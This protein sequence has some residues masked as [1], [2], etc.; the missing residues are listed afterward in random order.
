[1]SRMR[2]I[3]SAVCA[4]RMSRSPPAVIAGAAQ[5]RSGRRVHQRASP[6]SSPC[7]ACR[8]V[9][10]EFA[11]DPSAVTVVALNPVAANAAAGHSRRADSRRVLG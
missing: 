6:P 3:R 8:Q 7:G 2:P 11:A 4:E 9:L 5:P 10:L 1:M